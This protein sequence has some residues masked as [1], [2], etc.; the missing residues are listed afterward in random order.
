MVRVFPFTFEEHLIELI[1]NYDKMTWQDRYWR[2]IFPVKFIK[3]IKSNISFY[4]KDLSAG[5]DK[6]KELITNLLANFLSY[7][8]SSIAFF[9]SLL[10]LQR[11]QLNAYRMKPNSFN[12]PYGVYLEMR[13]YRNS[14][15][16]K[17]KRT[18]LCTWE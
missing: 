1:F 9:S 8:T 16:D 11:L 7:N 15:H 14:I 2:I 18:Y 10:L 17:E 6:G 3:T 4:V 13:L 5:R 12:V